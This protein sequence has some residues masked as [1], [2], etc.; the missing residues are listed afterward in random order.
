VSDFLS[1]RLCLL[2]CAK[3]GPAVAGP[4]DVRVVAEER[5]HCKAGKIRLF[6]VPDRDGVDTWIWHV[7]PATMKARDAA[8]NAEALGAFVLIDNVRSCGACGAGCGAVFFGRKQVAQWAGVDLEAV[9][10][11]PS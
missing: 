10:R 6:Q 7:A 9:P 2:F 1:P 8:I 11:V 4:A 5:T 3:R